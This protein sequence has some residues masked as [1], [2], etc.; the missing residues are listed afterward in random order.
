VRTANFKKQRI[1]IGT[2]NFGYAKKKFLSPS[3]HD[4]CRNS[5]TFFGADKSQNLDPVSAVFNLKKRK[6]ENFP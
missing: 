5:Q 3:T 2:H 6:K 4:L 1:P